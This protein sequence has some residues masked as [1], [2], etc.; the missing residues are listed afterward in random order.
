MKKITRRNAKKIDLRKVIEVVD[1]GEGM[2]V[3]VKLVSDEYKLEWFTKRMQNFA[4]ELDMR[5]L[6]CIGE[7]KAI[8]YCRGFEDAELLKKIFSMNV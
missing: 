2:S 1:T 5:V 7:Q 3:T 8:F 6:F 4:R